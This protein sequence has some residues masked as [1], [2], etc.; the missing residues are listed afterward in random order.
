MY[1]Y[2]WTMRSGK[3]VANVYKVS[4]W[5]DEVV[6]AVAPWWRNWKKHV[7]FLEPGEKVL[8]N[9]QPVVYGL[10]G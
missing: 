7:G 9:R 10:M 1:R 2:E 3:N 8:W 4:L 5:C 6:A